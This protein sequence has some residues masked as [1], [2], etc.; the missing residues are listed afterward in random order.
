MSERF[1]TDVPDFR[2]PALIEL[3]H[4]LPSWLADRLLRPDEKVTWV[5][6]PCFNPSWERY[7]THPALILFVLVPG[8]I[9]LGIAW[10]NQVDSA[11]LFFGAFFSFVVLGVPTI[12]VLAI[13]NGYFTRLVV[14]NHRLAILQGHE[15]CRIWSIDDLP[16]S[17][18]RYGRRGEE[19][20]RAV[21]LD[22][23]KTMLGGSS[24]KFTDAKTILKFG[25]QLDN[26]TLRD[27]NRR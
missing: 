8:A 4:P 17:L 24:D 13:A 2:V 12:I 6:G 22:V 25:K 16:P 19:E 7:I 9:G 23:V 11:K 26:I 1:P 5:H 27:K 14:T 20:G 15:I 18:L 3:F 21:D 10:L